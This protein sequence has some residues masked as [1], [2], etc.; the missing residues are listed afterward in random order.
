MRHKLAALPALAAL[1][2]LLGGC[3]SAPPATGSAAAGTSAA[4][5]NAPTG[6]PAQ[7]QALAR[8]TAYAGPP[9][10]SFTWLGRF[11]SWEPLGKDRLVVFTTPSDAY[12][13][14]VWPP[15]DLRF[16]M[17]GIG[18]TSTS[19]T[20]YAHMDSVVVR[21]GPGGPLKCPI[22]EIRK[23]DYRRLKAEQRQQQP[24]PPGQ[25]AAPN[26][27]APPTQAPPPGQTL[28]PGQAPQ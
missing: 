2:L 9:I 16:V 4:A 24:T 17:N 28:P 13:L 22:D 7:Q 8:Y 5:A 15:C 25:G 1:I 27:A 14:K 3:A 18:L 12:L 20:V 19:S 26:E 23:V 10:P 21:S 6:A 11:D